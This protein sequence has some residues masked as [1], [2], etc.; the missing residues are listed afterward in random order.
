MAGK[1]IQFGIKF[2]LVLT[3]LF[4][5]ALGWIGHN[6][7]LSRQEDAA[8]SAISQLCKDFEFNYGDDPNG[9]APGPAWI[10]SLWGQRV[11]ARVHGIRIKEFDPV[12]IKHLCSF[13]Q[14]RSLELL[15]CDEEVD[16]SGLGRLSHLE[17]VYFCKL[18]QFQQLTG[19]AGHRSLKEL[20]V[21]CDSFMSFRG[22]GDMPNLEYLSV[23]SSATID[24]GTLIDLPSLK[25]IYLRGNLPWKDCQILSQFPD[26][27]K[28][29]LVDF[30]NL[31]SLGG[32]ESL[33]SL[34]ELEVVFGYSLKDLTDIAGHPRLEKVELDGVF[35][36]LE[37]VREM[38]KLKSLVLDSHNLKSFEGL[39][40]LPQLKKILSGDSQVSDIS[41]VANCP[42]LQQL[43][44]SSYELSDLGPVQG[45]TDL[46]E[47]N[48]R[49]CRL[50]DLDFLADNSVLEVLDVE[51][52]ELA[53]ASGLASGSLKTLKLHSELPDDGSPI[54]IAGLAEVVERNPGLLNILLNRPEPAALLKIG[55]LKSLESLQLSGADDLENLDFL[56]SSPVIGLCLFE[57][58]NLKDVDVLRGN[59]RIGKVRMYKCG[60]ENLDGLIATAGLEELDISGCH[61]LQRI[62]GL[63]KSTSLKSLRLEYCKSLNSLKG[64]SGCAVLETLDVT[65]APEVSDIS[66]VYKLLPLE[67]L[68]LP[69]Q[70][71]P[72]LPQL[73]NA[74]PDAFISF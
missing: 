42:A 49:S 69:K 33:K 23:S 15:T 62:D 32:I 50:N 12:I 38:P 11:F 71:S 70:F 16:L 59:V 19:F 4:A 44:I 6:A 74:H 14:L 30:E 3:L 1:R 40:E 24:D 57:C 36:D 25:E 26:L 5:V 43:Q 52:W 46:T 66:V 41:P 55:Q 61:Q 35:P 37:G 58:P 54:L 13:R 64:I 20:I 51:C 18:K 56:E 28:V 45:L 31:E 34:K 67:S 9:S 48:L 22:I 47:L 17:S 68:R 7:N 60:I 2:V 73:K 72:Q 8:I 53:D 39:S 27:E 29:S 21:D 63:S 10:R 65:D